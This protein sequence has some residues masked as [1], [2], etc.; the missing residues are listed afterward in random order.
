[1]NDLKPVLAVF[2][3]VFFGVFTAAYFN[4]EKSAVVC[5]FIIS[6]GLFVLASYMMLKVYG[7]VK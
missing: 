3:G 6:L 5:L 4:T 1:M 2:F 7:V